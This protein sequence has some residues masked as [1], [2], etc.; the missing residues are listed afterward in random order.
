MLQQW[1][2]DL[3]ALA[4]QPNVS[5]KL[6]GL[7]TET[8]GKPW[9]TDLVRPYLTHAIDVFGTAR[10][11]FG[12]DW[13]VLTTAGS[14]QQWLAAVLDALLGRTEAEIAQVMSGN[15]QSTYRLADLDKEE[16]R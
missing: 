3:S 16:T 7:A 5:C 14:Y 6:S 10:C 13:P 15:A 11:L 12:S 9:S 2:D 4:E 1:R 8:G